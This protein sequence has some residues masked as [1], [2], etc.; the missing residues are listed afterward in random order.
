[1]V[2]FKITKGRSFVE[3][4]QTPEQS[5]RKVVEQGCPVAMKYL[6]SLSEN[7]HTNHSYS[8]ILRFLLSPRRGAMLTI[9]LRKRVLLLPGAFPVWHSRCSPVIST[10]IKICTTQHVSTKKGT[11]FLLEESQ[12]NKR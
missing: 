5:P 7:S 1:M 3:I 4:I 12:H 10:G 6:R 2:G 8:S 9:L 11:N